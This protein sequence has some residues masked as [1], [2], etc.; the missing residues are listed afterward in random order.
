MASRWRRLRRRQ[1]EYGEI[2]REN[3]CVGMAVLPIFLFV[4]LV[5]FF[6]K[7]PAFKNTPTDPV[8]ESSSSICNF[9]LDL[10]RKKSY[11]AVAKLR[12]EEAVWNFWNE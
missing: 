7:S 12:K 10:K 4:A 2:L 9:Y 5:I 3:G 1:T 6:A 11:N 8:I